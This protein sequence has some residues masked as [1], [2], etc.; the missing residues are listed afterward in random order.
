MVKYHK[1]DGTETL[2]TAYTYDV[3]DQVTLMEDYEKKNGSWE[4]YRSTK[5]TYDALKRMSSYTEWDGEGAAPAEPTVSYTYDIEG[6]V[7]AVDYAGTGSELTG[8]TF[9]YD[10]S[11]KLTK[12]KAKTGGLLSDTVREYSYDDQ[13]RVSTIRDHY[14]FTGSGSY[15]EKSYTYDDFGR[16][17]SMAYRGGSGHN[18]IREAYVYTYDRNNNIKSERIVS[19][20]DKDDSGTGRDITRVYTYDTAGRLTE[21][22]ETDNSDGTAGTGITLYTYDK[23]G[24]RLTETKY[25]STT[26][27][28]Y[29]DLDQLTECRTTGETKTY[30]YDRNGNQTSEITKEGSTEKERRT[31][32]YDEA[33]RL[34]N[35]AVKED[36]QLILTQENRYNGSGQ[37]ISKAETKLA[38]DLNGETTETSKT[39]YFYQDGAVLYTKDADGNRSSMN[40]LGTS[41]NVIATSRGTG[42]SEN[43]YLYNKDIREST[44]S[45]IGANGSAAVTYKYDDFGNTKLTGGTGID[46]EICYTGQIYDRSTGLYYYNARYYDPKNARF[47]TQDTYRGENDQPDTLHL[48]AYCANN[49]INYVDPTGHFVWVLP[50]LFSSMS[51]ASVASF[52]GGAMCAVAS[53]A[54]GL[55]VK[56]M[57]EAWNKTQVEFVTIVAM[58]IAIKESLK[59]GKKKGKSPNKHKHH[60][61][62]KKDGRAAY[63]RNI[64]SKNNIGIN[65]K[66]NLVSLKKN[67]HQ[68]L[69]TN[70]YHKGVNAVMGASQKFATVLRRMYPKKVKK[71]DIR[72][73]K[74]VTA[75]GALRGMKVV[76]KG[77]NACAK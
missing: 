77:A 53:V 57:K 40:L 59:K 38:E 31:F 74:G 19:D 52:L 37:R 39:D 7:T 47:L 17:T 48:Y 41:A 24:N 35:L 28:S 70:R 4:L 55:P 8:L 50:A 16:V 33:D 9:E 3:N 73:L 64:L 42:N 2:K 65:S 18:D 27:Y 56:K 62:A 13:G 71:S 63:A 68:H 36:D 14:A 11:R 1:A 20:Y 61:V 49:P 34:K 67:F 72:K 10:S 15:L 54:I 29:N 23:A 25:G 76:L 69:H 30:S 32:V 21:T 5:Y 51:A 12:I 26:S 58:V 44:T 46:N 75:K 6:N 66:R 43:W 45:I 60:I 22:R